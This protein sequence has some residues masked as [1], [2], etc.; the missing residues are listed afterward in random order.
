MSTCSDP[1]PDFTHFS[2]SFVSPPA[3]PKG[4]GWEQLKECERRIRIEPVAEET[5]G[6]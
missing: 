3:Q 2:Y 5:T 1:L 4:R 6:V